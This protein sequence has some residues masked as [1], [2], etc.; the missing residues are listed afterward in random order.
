MGIT[1]ICEKAKKYVNFKYNLRI[2]VDWKLMHSLGM[3]LQYKALSGDELDVLNKSYLSG[4]DNSDNLVNNSTIGLPVQS[5]GRSSVN[6]ME[7][8]NN[9]DGST[10]SRN[11]SKQTK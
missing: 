11:Y 3:R 9:G 10:R 2:N 8:S 4:Q 6:T 1:S 5:R 7:I